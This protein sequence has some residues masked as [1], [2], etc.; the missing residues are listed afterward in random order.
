[1]ILVLK[2]SQMIQLV[3]KNLFYILISGEN[4]FLKKY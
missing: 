2:K 4:L 3:N 1:M